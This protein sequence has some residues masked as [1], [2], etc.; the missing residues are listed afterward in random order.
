MNPGASDLLVRM[1]NTRSVF[2]LLGLILVLG[3]PHVCSRPAAIHD[4]IPRDR[5]AN[6][7]IGEEQAKVGVGVVYVINCYLFR[8]HTFS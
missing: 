2:L 6:C 5:F 3:L 8:T 4:Y 1:A 7:T